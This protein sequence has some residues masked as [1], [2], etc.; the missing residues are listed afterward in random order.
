MKV[1][2]KTSEEIELM[3]KAGKILAGNV[4]FRH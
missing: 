4:Y 3:R 1:T 2:I